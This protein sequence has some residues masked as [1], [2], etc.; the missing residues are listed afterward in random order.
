MKDVGRSGLGNG[1]REGRR[2][3]RRDR[4]ACRG[5]HQGRQTTGAS[6]R[7]RT[8]ASAVASLGQ[9]TGAWGEGQGGRELAPRGE[10]EIFIERREQRRR[11]GGR[12]KGPAAV[13]LPLMETLSALAVTVFMGRG[14]VEQT[15]T[16]ARDAPRTG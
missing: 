12:R 11:R 5:S 16:T 7:R 3:Q 6:W 8:A 4:G 10:G 13:C 1:G 9:R 14:G 2:A 15:N